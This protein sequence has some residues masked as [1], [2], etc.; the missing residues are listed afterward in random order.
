MMGQSEVSLEDLLDIQ[1][2]ESLAMLG[3]R[4]GKDLLG[5]LVALF[6]DQGPKSFKQ[7]RQ[8]LAEGDAT[9]VSETAHSL[10]G[11]Y[12]SLGTVRLAQISETLERRGREG[13]LDGLD[14]E[15]SELE[16]TFSVTERQLEAFLEQRRAKAGGSG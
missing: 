6:S 16:E 10:K 8:A 15:L 12:R 11:S 13:Q 5:Q 9:T 1:T 14:A 7:L 4:R 3:E 2:L